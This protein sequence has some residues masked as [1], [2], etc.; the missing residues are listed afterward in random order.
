MFNP[1][2]VFYCPCMF[3]SNRGPQPS[4]RKS[5]EDVTSIVP[6]YFMYGI[7]T[8]IYHMDVSENSGT[9]KSSI[10]IG[11]SIINHPFWGSPIFGN[12]HIDL[13][14][15]VGKYSSP[16][17]GLGVA[18]TLGSQLGSMM[19]TFLTLRITTG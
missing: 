13:I 19:S 6:K 1:L 8:Y 4:D 2:D 11:L 5:D 9:S 12:T 15:H 10:L 3:S 7:F 14:Q 16:M 17:E 18:K